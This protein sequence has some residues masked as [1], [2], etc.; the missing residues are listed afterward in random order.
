MITWHLYID[1]HV[2][3]LR[4]RNCIQKDNN[5]YK[6]TI[7]GP[8]TDDLDPDPGGVLLEGEGEPGTSVTAKYDYDRFRSQESQQ[9]LPCGERTH[10][11]NPKGEEV[12][13]NSVND[14]VT[15]ENA[16]FTDMLKQV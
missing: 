10:H 16:F 8:I 3:L 4:T 11:T 2:S 15:C 6:S 5:E 9:Q 1:D 7:I 14:V 12:W 13:C